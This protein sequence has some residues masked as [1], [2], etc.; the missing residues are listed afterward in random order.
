MVDHSCSTVFLGSQHDIVFNSCNLVRV[1]R[2]LRSPCPSHRGRTAQRLQV[3]RP[4]RSRHSVLLSHT[5]RW[6]LVAMSEHRR[7]HCALCLPTTADASTQLSIPEFLQ[8]CFTKHPFRRTAA[9]QLHEDL[10]DAQ[11]P[12]D[13]V[14]R[15]GDTFA[16]AATELSFA[17]FFEHCILFPPPHI[18]LP[19]AHWC[20]N[21]ISSSSGCNGLMPVPRTQPD[22]TQPPPP[23]L[24]DRALLGSHHNI[25]TKA[26]PVRPIRIKTLHQL[27]QARRIH[28]P[29]RQP[30]N[31]RS[32]PP[33][34]EL[35]P[36]A[37]QLL[38]K[39]VQV[40]P[41]REPT[42]PSVQIHALDV[43]YS[44]SLVLLSCPW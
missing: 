28:L 37:H 23:G 5:F 19:Q 2:R 39:G 40:P 12:S 10:S 6:A 35:T 21:S 31:R 32:V 42:L 4:A 25:I 33:K 15:R 17:E 1:S 18:P 29:P 3:P 7:G 27:R 16:D 30:Y 22:C 8:L 38:T 26:A 24:E 20:C 9:L 44:R 43:V 11:C 14:N 13:S 41:W 36:L 34:W